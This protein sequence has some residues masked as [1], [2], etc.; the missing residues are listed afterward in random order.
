[1]NEPVKGDLKIE[2]GFEWIFDGINWLKICG[3]GLTDEEIDDVYE[4][5]CGMSGDPVKLYQMFKLKE[6]DK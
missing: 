5:W 3:N 2:N 4:I 1:M 6:Q